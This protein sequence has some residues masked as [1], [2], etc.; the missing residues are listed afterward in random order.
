VRWARLSERAHLSAAGLSIQ[1]RA[2]LLPVEGGP[3]LWGSPTLSKEL[4]G[5][6][7]VE[8]VPV[9]IDWAGE[10]ADA[11]DIAVDLCDLGHS[12]SCPLA[13]NDPSPFCDGAR[14]AGLVYERPGQA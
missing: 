13:D 4:S 6:P 8:Q 12:T 1:T 3:G 14:V 11:Y 5:R 2:L 10:R 9:T 7:F